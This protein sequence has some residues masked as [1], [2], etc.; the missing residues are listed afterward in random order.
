MNK[1]LYITIV[2][3]SLCQNI[4][5]FDGDIAFEYLKKQCEFGHRYPGSKEHIKLKDYFIDFLSDKVDSL[6]VYSHIINHPYT[7]EE[8]TL[9]NEVH[10]MLS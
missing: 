1:I 6:S 4:P 3:L 5:H 10:D 8:I 9:F 2:S 7:K